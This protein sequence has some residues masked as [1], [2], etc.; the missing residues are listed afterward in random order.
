MKNMILLVFTLLTSFTQISAAQS[1]NLPFDPEPY[2]LCIPKMGNDKVWLNAGTMVILELNEDLFSNR[3]TRGQNVLMRVRTDVYAEGEIV[4]RTGAQAFGRV[5]RV[6]MGTN[7]DP[8]S[9][10]IELFYVQSV[11]MQQVPLHGNEQTL[12]GENSNTNSTAPV[13]SNI[14]AHV[15]NNMKIEV[16]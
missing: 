8:S 2:K 14:T 13:M 7:N 10:T 5:K 16:K 1:N 6:E 9:I 4:I 12:I 3:V 15:M 11:D